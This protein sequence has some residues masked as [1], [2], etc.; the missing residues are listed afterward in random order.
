MGIG[1]TYVK[2]IMR[3][4][5]DEHVQ[6]CLTWQPRCGHY[7]IGRLVVPSEWLSLRS[8]RLAITLG[9]KRVGRPSSH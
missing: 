6:P 1:T 2:V 7:E 9:E 5:R 3:R 4:Y 8:G